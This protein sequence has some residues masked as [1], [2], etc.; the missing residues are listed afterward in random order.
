MLVQELKSIPILSW[1]DA[2]SVKDGFFDF[3]SHAPQ[4]YPDL[5]YAGLPGRKL[6]VAH[7]PGIVRHVL[8]QNHLNY[9]K[10]EGY[11]ILG[12]LLGNGLITNP[13][14]TSWRKQR[15]LMQPAFHRESLRTMCEIVTSSTEQLLQRWKTRQGSVINFTHDMAWL[16]I[17]IVS[18]TLFTTDVSDVQIQMI[19]DNLNFL[20]E[21]ATKMM[22]NPFHIPW[23]YPYP[24]HVRARKKISMLDELIYG[25]I[26]KRRQ[27]QSPHRDLL[28]MLIEA[29]YEDGSVMSDEQIR[30]EVMTVFVAGHETTVNA[31]SWTW[32]CLKKTPE[33]ENHLREESQKFAA[34]RKPVFEDI[35]SMQFGWQVMNESMRLY[36]PVPAI[37]R[38]IVQNDEAEGYELKA[39]RKVVINITGLHHHPAYWEKPF[40]FYPAHFENFEMKGDNR[41]IFM[42]FGA[43]P[44]IC[45]G[46]NFAML[47]MQLINAMFSARVEMELVSKEITP[48][49][50][51]TLKPGDGVMMRLKSVTS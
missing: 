13:D 18:K 26:R 3:L 27:Q 48:V 10:D 29:R 49:P 32:Y 7:H 8:Q 5:F 12:L 15:A 9:R 20:N 22:R 34:T 1:R 50:L 38:S 6:Y 40:E 47:E 33:Y 14:A 39:G 25:I 24:R 31:L 28:Q 11:R 44:R 37:G 51:I 35:P 41:F 46:N 21:S 17:D 19:W 16:T 23:K 42:P 36:P 45:I 2:F 30:D 43:G 4:R